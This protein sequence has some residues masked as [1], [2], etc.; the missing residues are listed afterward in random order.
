MVSAAVLHSPEPARQARRAAAI[1]LA[2]AEP[3]E[4]PAE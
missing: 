2:H 1:L 3:E 4:T